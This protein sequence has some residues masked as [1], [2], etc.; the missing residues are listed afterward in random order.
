MKKEPLLVPIA[1]EKVALSKRSLR[2]VKRD[3]GNLVANAVAVY[4]NVYVVMSDGVVITVARA[5]SPLVH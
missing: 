2:E 3:Y 4:R 5:K 1:Y